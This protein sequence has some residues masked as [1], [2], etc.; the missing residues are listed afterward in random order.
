MSEYLETTNDEIIITEITESIP[1]QQKVLTDVDNA[2]A[3]NTV[4]TTSIT[5][6]VTTTTTLVETPSLP[7]TSESKDN[8]LSASDKYDED[9][10]SLSTSTSAPAPKPPVLSI[11]K[12]GIITDVLEF[13][14]S[15][16]N[17]TKEFGNKAP[18]IDIVK[19]IKERTNT[20]IEMST[21]MRTGMTTFLI[22]GKVEDV[23]RA[24]RELKTALAV[25]TELIIKVPASVRRHIFGPGGSTLKSIISRTGTRIQLPKRDTIEEKVEGIDEEE[26]MMDIRIE[27]DKEGVGMAKAEIETIVVEKTPKRVQKISHIQHYFYPLIAGAHNHSVQQIALQTDTKIH[28]PTY[29]AALDAAENNES[30][31]KDGHITVIGNAENVKQACERIEDVYNE[32]KVTT[33][34]LTVD[35]PKRQH[36]YLIGPKGANLQEILEVTGCSLELAPVSDP[37]EVVTIRGPAAKLSEATKLVMDKA[38]SINVEI[39]DITNIHKAENPLEHAKNV[40]KYLWNRGKLRKIEG[41]SGN[42]QIIVPKGGTLNNS[43]IF[44]FVGKSP[45][46]VEKARKEVLELVK[47]LPPSYF[48]TVAVDPL[49]HRHIIGRK[50]QNLQRVKETYGVEIIVPG[51]KDESPDIIIVYE[52]K[53]PSSSQPANPEKKKEVLVKETLEQAKNEL[54]KAAQDASDFATQSLTIPVKYHRHI[55]GPKGT[56]LNKIT[57]GVDTPVSVKFGSLRTGA[58]ERSA[59]AEGKR[60]ANMQPSD[61]LVI[62]KGPTEEV[63]RV[64]AEIERVVKDAEF[65]EARNSYTATFTLPSQYSA[66]I[67]GKG[68]AT[69]TRLKDMHNVKIE[70]DGPQK[71]SNDAN[72]DNAKVHKRKE[73][74]KNH[75]SDEVKVTILGTERN[76][77]EAKEKILDLIDKIKNETTLN[78]VIPAEYH[79]SLIGRNGVY[80]KRLEEK[81]GVHIRFPWNKA[82]DEDGNNHDGQKPNEV[83]IRGGKKGVKNASDEIMELFEYERDHNNSVSFT[84]PAKSLSYILGRKGQRITEIKNDTFSRIEF[85]SPQPDPSTEE[86]VIE[87]KVFGT[88]SDIQRARDIIQSLVKDLGSQ[89]TVTMHID[90]SYHGYLIGPSGSRIKEIVARASEPENKYKPVQA[91]VVKFP[92]PWE[93]SDEVILSG[94][95][96]LVERIQ[97]QLEKLILGRMVDVIQIPRAEHSSIIGRSGKSLKELQSHYNVEIYF[98]GSRS[99]DDV[100]L[101]SDWEDRGIIK[102]E[103]VKIIGQKEDIICAKAEIM[104][105]MRYTSTVPIPLKYYRIL[106]SDGSLRRIHYDFNIMVDHENLS[107]TQRANGKPKRIDD[108]DEQEFDGELKM[109]VVEY[110]KEDEGEEVRMHLKGDKKQV[111][112]AEKHLDELLQGASAYTH[113]GYI[114]IPQYFHRHIIGRDGIT[115]TSIRS[116]SGCLINVPKDNGQVVLIG[117]AESIEKARKRIQEIVSRAVKTS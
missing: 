48:D 59:S 22:M 73:A 39:L 47:N 94:E 69:I 8:K 115:I 18:T 70:I 42:L 7:Q 83:I 54:I 91:N 65:I 16:Q 113:T 114:T 23:Q 109:E 25:K 31:Q 86:E 116:E 88:L 117:T 45:D 106:S 40:L 82:G 80:V 52:D 20:Q 5:A 102:E 111:E 13:P 33:R 53:V 56:T 38:S 103:L 97:E 61:D 95:I 64:V 90:Q 78:L 93:Q 76:V 43:V 55:I 12:T 30:G 60:V 41:D 29:V 14:A 105:R 63:E 49:L 17:R 50:G 51:E 79:K 68:G 11:R 27:G 46:I 21:A 28:I 24:K 9:F 44:E 57:G 32:L 81:Y 58:A 77:E 72:A 35:I 2:E 6:A 3:I 4:T 34:T 89:K 104:S 112:A 108:D 96:G 71:A 66:H 36:K 107:E 85:G 10:P 87:V 101:P 99:Y 84:I 19:R 62:I 37:N 75:S 1:S 26:E 92:K 100:K 15:Q 67:I 74:D 110:G 98:P